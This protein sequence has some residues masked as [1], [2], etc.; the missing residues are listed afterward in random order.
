VKTIK[1]KGDPK[2]THENPD[3]N[4]IDP[5]R[6]FYSYLHAKADA[7]K[8][9]VEYLPDESQ[10]FTEE[11]G[12]DKRDLVSMD[13]LLER[14]HAIF[15]PE[16]T[17]NMMDQV[18]ESIDEILNESAGEEEEESIKTIGNKIQNYIKKEITEVK[19]AWNTEQY[20]AA[21][22]KLFA[23]S[24]VACLEENGWYTDPNEVSDKSS[25]E[26]IF[27]QI[28]NLWTQMFSKSDKFLDENLSLGDKHFIYVMMDSLHK[29]C[30]KEPLSYKWTFTKPKPLAPESLKWN[31][32]QAKYNAPIKT[33]GD[34]SDEEDDEDMEDEDVEDSDNYGMEEEEDGAGQAEGGEEEEP[35]G[36][37]S[38]K[39]R[40]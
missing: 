2:D 18:R 19:N 34:I 30:T 21:F 35:T 17:E 20:Q 12:D 1:K 13:T 38:K 6:T 25:V 10:D 36:P 9:A 29:R 26:E 16:S 5:F 4:K 37:P 40:I 14:L 11:L 23:L 31:I 15:L 27:Q 22:D 24:Y 39:R 3:A 28:S 32:E 8:K 7:L 33:L